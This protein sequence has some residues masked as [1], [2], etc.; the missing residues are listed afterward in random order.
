MQQL[1]VTFDSAGLRLAGTMYLPSKA[2]DGKQPAIVIGH[3][4]SGVKEQTADL[5]ARHLAEQGFVTL[6][7]DAA[8]GGESEGEPRGLEDPGHRVEDIKAAISFLSARDG[9]DSDRL[10]LLGICALGGYAVLAAATDHR[11][12]AVATISG[13]DIGRFFRE[14][15]D[16]KQDPQV[17][18]AM[19]DHAGKAR[20]AEARGEDVQHF[21]IFPESESDA[22]QAGQYVYEGWEYYCTPRAAHPRSTK[23][24]PWSSVDR[25]ATFNGF[26]LI[27]L[28]SP[29]PLLMVVGTKAATRWMTEGAF[30]RAGE[31]KALHWI[32]G[33]SH[34]DLY[35]KAEYVVPA[36]AA[37]SAFY[38]KSLSK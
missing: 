27:H 25:I 8:Y 16:G 37:L 35:D 12:K 17:L 14:G 13:T 29:R 26:S 9:I 32:E 5:Y 7:F 3:P 11:V 38:K 34:V 4:S 10:G 19:L 23:M 6:T 15:Y 36:V 22:R 24:M 21:A 20:T 33:A 31:P 18:Q 1:S 2:A 28:I 30:A